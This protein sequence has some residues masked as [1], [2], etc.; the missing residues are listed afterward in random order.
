MVMKLGLVGRRVHDMNR[1][2]LPSYC[3]REWVKE[4]SRLAYSEVVMNYGVATLMG[5][6]SMRGIQLW[7]WFGYLALRFVRVDEKK[8]TLC[9]NVNRQIKILL[10]EIH[11]VEGIP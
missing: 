11:I 4:A 5:S 2:Y 3:W 8:A 10:K 9:V 6:S 7:R 1:R